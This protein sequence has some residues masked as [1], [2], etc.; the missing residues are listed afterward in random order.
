MEYLS[1]GGAKRKNNVTGDTNSAVKLEVSNEE[2]S[3]GSLKKQ[4]NC[5]MNLRSI[6]LLDSAIYCAEVWSI[7]ADYVH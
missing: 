2:E 6:M 3:V 1:S 4:V 7:W 5:F